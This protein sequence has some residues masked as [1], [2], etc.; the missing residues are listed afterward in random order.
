MCTVSAPALP[1]GTHEGVGDAL[2]RW[3]GRG[4]GRNAP[5]RGP[6]W[7]PEPDGPHPGGPSGAGPAPHP[8]CPR[9][10]R[11]GLG[12]PG[13][14]PAD[15]PAPLTCLR[16]AHLGAPGQAEE[17]AQHL[18]SPGRPHDSAPTGSAA[19]PDR[20]GAPGLR[21]RS[22]PPEVPAAGSGGR[23]VAKCNRSRSRSPGR[24]GGEGCV[25]A[26][27][28]GSAGGG[29][30][31][32]PRP[33]GRGA[34]ARAAGASPAAGAPRPLPRGGAGR[35]EEGLLPTL[36]SGVGLKRG[37]GS[38]HPQMPAEG[39]GNGGGESAPKPGPRKLAAPINQIT[40]LPEP[41]GSLGGFS[42]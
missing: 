29:R 18:Q 12:A 7:E 34:G 21:H 41:V 24:D 39:S 19:R 20:P 30:E 2:G 10:P 5:P 36:S 27:E 25:S 26:R 4:W 32:R 42:L 28:G 9:T 22:Q 35:A 3:C 31:S 33:R 1:S 17:E 23:G 15:A 37:Q 16:G 13:S 11:T 6:P 38:K 14:E 8:R 40:Q